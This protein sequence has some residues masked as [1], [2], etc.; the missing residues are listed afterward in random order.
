MSGADEFVQS[1]VKRLQQAGVCDADRDVMAMLRVAAEDGVY[2]RGDPISGDMAA[3]FEAMLVKRIA[4]MP[5]SQIIGRR[6]FWS[7]DFRVTKDVLDPRPDTETLVEL[8]FAEPFERVLD[9]GCGSGCILLSL[10]AEAPG[11]TGVG[12]DVSAK[13]LAVA[14]ENARAIGVADR[15]SLVDSDWFTKVEGRFDLIVSNPPYIA[16]QEMADLAP[17]VRDHEPH[18]ALTDGGD[19]LG[20]YRDIADGLP[21]YLTP[22]GRVLLEIGPTQAREVSQM[23]AHAGLEIIEVHPDL[24]GRDRVV[25]ARAR[26]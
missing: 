3:R 5:V 18:I 26:Q 4:R 8:A 19:G 20:A 22:R 17:E 12:G 1:A 2:L 7:H 6:A 14:Q 24:D 16:L 13:A 10:L 25:S 21:D 9:L 11:A 23:L 15:V